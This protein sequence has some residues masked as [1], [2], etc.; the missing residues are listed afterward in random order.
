MKAKMKAPK[1]VDEYLLYLPDDKRIIL[2]KVRAA[3]KKAAPKTEESIS[4][5]M[6]GYKYK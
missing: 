1:S 6:P 2:E 3:I 5:G 4:Y